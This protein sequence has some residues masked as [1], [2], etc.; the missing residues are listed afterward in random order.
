[1]RT[2]PLEVDGCSLRAVSELHADVRPGAYR[3]LV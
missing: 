1:V 3:L 2:I